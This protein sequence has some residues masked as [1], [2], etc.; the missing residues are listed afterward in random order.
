MYKSRSPEDFDISNSIDDMTFLVNSPRQRQSSSESI[1]SNNKLIESLYKV[2][3][4][5]PGDPQRISFYTSVVLSFYFLRLLI[6]FNDDEKCWYDP[7]DDLPL[8]IMAN[9]D[10]S[11]S[12]DFNQVIDYFMDPKYL[13]RNYKNK[14]RASALAM[15]LRICSSYQLQQYLGGVLNDAKTS[16]LIT[17][18]VACCALEAYSRAFVAINTKFR[19]IEEPQPIAAPIL[20]RQFTGEHDNSSDDE[21]EFSNPNTP[22]SSPPARTPEPS[23]PMRTPLHNNI[24]THAHTLS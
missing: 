2:T 19:K 6:C 20:F 23:G 9:L 4:V 18:I 1:P 10:V 22:S 16:A 5:E 13:R 11:W 7:L 14:V 17:Q 24:K 15:T 3:N 21:Y 12:H 8:L